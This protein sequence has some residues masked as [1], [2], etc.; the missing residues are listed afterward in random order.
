MTRI[1]TPKRTFVIILS[2]FII[3][4]FSGIPVCFV[5]SFGEIHFPGRNGT[6]IGLI[7][8]EDRDKV[9]KT[10][11]ITNYFVIP[12]AAFL[13]ISVCTVALTF[14]LRKTAKWRESVT[15][16]SQSNF[17]N[18]KVAKMVV[19]V[20]T[21]FI[22]CFIPISTFMLVLAL[23]PQLNLGGKY[24]S[25]GITLGSISVLL[26]SVNSSVNIFIYY[27]MSSK[28]RTTFLKIF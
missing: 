21:L 2:V 18:L 26:E 12:F 24:Q 17:R 7:P 25:I 11:Y 16:F 13:I 9:E 28:Y 14:S 20:S 1:V 27:H 5:Y 19:I 22:F 15:S 3:L 10:T 23:E 4:V 6:V 8:T